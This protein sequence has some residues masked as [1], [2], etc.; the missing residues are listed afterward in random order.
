MPTSSRLVKQIEVAAATVVE[1]GAQQALREASSACRN[2]KAQLDLGQGR[3]GRRVGRIAECAASEVIGPRRRRPRVQTTGREVYAEHAAWARSTRSAGRRR[4]LELKRPR[5]RGVPEASARRSATWTS[6]AVARPDD[7]SHHPRSTSRRSCASV[8]QGIKVLSLFFI[9]KVSQL[10]RTTTTKATPSRASTPGVVRGGVQA[11]GHPQPEV[12]DGLFQAIDLAHAAEESTTATSR[13]TRRSAHDHS[14]SILKDSR[15]DTHERRR[16]GAYQLIMK[17]QGAAAQLR[18]QVQVHLLPLRAAGRL[19]QPQRLPDLQPSRQARPNAERRQTIGRG[20]RLCVNQQGE[21]AAR[22]RGEHAHGGRDRDATRSSPPE[23]A[24]RNG[25]SQGRHRDQASAS[26]SRKPCLRRASRFAARHRDR[27]STARATKQSKALCGAHLRAKGHIDAKGRVQDSLA[28][29]HQ[30]REA[31]GPARGTARDRSSV[32]SPTKLRKCSPARLEVKN[33][34]ERRTRC[35]SRQAVLLSP[36]F[37][38]LWDRIKH[39]TTYR[40]LFDNEK[41]IERCIRRR[42]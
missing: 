23:P 18:Q 33:A 31:L 1:G 37:K 4:S 11:P 42:S 40:V 34:D 39:K 15:G 13:S 16:P 9:D 24:A 10:P 8:P 3:A 22:V 17:R 41:L 20:L 19:G 14:R 21:R 38:A 35:R 7:P 2:K 27:S 5:R 30:G 29:R 36:E 12:P 26:W 28:D 6:S 32:R 25:G